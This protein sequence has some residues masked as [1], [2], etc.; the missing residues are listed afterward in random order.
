MHLSTHLREFTTWAGPGT[1]SN[2]IRV[3]PSCRQLLFAES[4][5]PIVVMEGESELC[6]RRADETDTTHAEAS[7]SGSKG[8]L[9]TGPDAAAAGVT[10]ACPGP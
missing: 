1:S 9:Q 6:S 8:I 10:G 7:E 5:T 3:A 2:L 4:A